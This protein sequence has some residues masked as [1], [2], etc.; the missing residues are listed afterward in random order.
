MPLGLP[1]LTP[2]LSSGFGVLKN[3]AWGTLKVCAQEWCLGH[4]PQGIL[5]LGLMHV[6]CKWMDRLC[7][8]G[9]ASDHHFCGIDVSQKPSEPPV[10]RQKPLDALKYSIPCFL[11]WRLLADINLVL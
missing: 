2:C 9:G 8:C 11:L 7:C 5:T 6:K 4:S 3:G 1:P 10:L